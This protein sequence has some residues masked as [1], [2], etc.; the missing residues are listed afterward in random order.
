[1]CGRFVSASP[2]DDIARYFDAAAPEQALGE[3][4]NVA[5]TNDVYAVY[6]DG[7]VRR[8]DAF[9][10]GLVPHWA[11]DPSVGNRM[12]NA[13]AET[14]AGK[15][16]FKPSLRKRRCLIP[17]DGF[18]EWKKVEGQKKKQPMFI[19]RPD[20][21]PLAF[22]GLWTIWRNPEVEGEELHSCT[23]ITTQANATM[24]PIHDR[25][26]VIL[27]QADWDQ[28]LDPANDDVDTLGKLLVPAPPKLIEVFPV[29][30]DVNSVRNKGPE[31]IARVDPATG[32]IHGQGTLL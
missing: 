22:A 12:I 8:L 3:N 16:A 14:V 1:M 6:E 11:K 19:H 5:P 15:N 23:I 28:W 13:R 24:E 18:Y 31:L 10:W 2:P 20:E 21:Q 30:T 17:A 29:S 25:M 26:P 32:E 7:G 9:H 4:Y 27:D